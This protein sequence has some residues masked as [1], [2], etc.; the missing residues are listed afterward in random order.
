VIFVEIPSF[1]RQI[2][3]LAVDD[4][5]QGLQK[6]LL[7]APKKGDV[8]PHSGGLRKMRMKLP[9]R[10]KSAGA[11]IIYLY[12]EEREIVILFYAYTKAERENLSQAQLDALRKAVAIIKREFK[13]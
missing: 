6:E 3:D 1:T 8:I 4:I 12:L 11:R 13:V 10:G 9:G 7:K 5:Y 2:N